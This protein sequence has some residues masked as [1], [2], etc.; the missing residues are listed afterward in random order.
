MDKNTLE[1]STEVEK[2]NDGNESNSGANSSDEN[3]III[4]EMTIITEEN[5]PQIPTNR[6]IELNEV[7]DL[8]SR[9]NQN[10]PESGKQTEFDT[11]SEACNQDNSREAS[12]AV[13]CEKSATNNSASTMISE[14]LSCEIPSE[15]TLSKSFSKVSNETTSDQLDYTNISNDTLIQSSSA[16]TLQT[17]LIHNPSQ[18]IE[19]KS[20]IITTQPFTSVIT[21][22]S[23]AFQEEEVKDTSSSVIEDTNS[24]VSE[25]NTKNFPIKANTTPVSTELAIN[26]NISEVQQ[27]LQHQSLPPM[28]ISESSKT[29]PT[30]SET[31]EFE[32]AQTCATIPESLDNLQTKTSIPSKNSAAINFEVIPGGIGAGTPE[33]PKFVDPNV[34]EKDNSRNELYAEVVVIN[35]DD[36]DDDDE[37][38]R[39]ENEIVSKEQQPNETVEVNS[40]TG[41]EVKKVEGTEV[42]SDTVLEERQNSVGETSYKVDKAKP[43]TMQFETPRKPAPSVDSRTITRPSKIRTQ[44]LPEATVTPFSKTESESATAD[45][46]TANTGQSL[47]PPAVSGAPSYVSSQPPQILGQQS[48]I[49]SRSQQGLPPNSVQQQVAASKPILQQATAPKIIPQSEHQQQPFA[50]TTPMRG[51]TH[52]VVIPPNITPSVPVISTNPTVVSNAPVAAQGPHNPENSQREERKSLQRVRQRTVTVQSQISLDITAAYNEVKQNACLMFTFGSFIFPRNM[53]RQ[54]EWMNS[55]D[56]ATELV[57]RVQAIVATREKEWSAKNE[58]LTQLLAHE[59]KRNEPLE[60]KAAERLLAMAEYEK[61][62]QE[63]VEELRKKNSD[64]KNCLGESKS[65]GRPGPERN[66]SPDDVTQLLKERDQ[67]AE[68]VNSL[69]TS[70]GELF[71]RYEKLRQ[72]SV[73]IKRNEDSVKSAS[74]EMARR[75]S[76]LVEKFEMLRRNAEEQLDLANNEIERLIKQHEADTLG[77]RLKVKHQESKIDS[78][79]VSLEARQKELESMTAIFEEVITKAEANDAACDA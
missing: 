37:R 76:L 59:Q 36:D 10:S 25:N 60:Q 13:I 42:A 4:P 70:Y 23:A 19:P 33:I 54:D 73:E 48:S 71:R 78:L 68:E 47:P 58:K 65:V 28:T 55:D 35:D 69:E 8:P 30:S 14:S 57:R 24:L 43:A 1:K 7:V 41:S 38:R 61:L 26:A 29:S 63:F 27:L 21:A 40:M 11:V 56:P 18:N 62:V 20:P 17:E 72:T 9:Q 45:M 39:A 32:L 79:T 15:Q 2:A 6:T 52:P 16:E 49:A 75:Y 34:M 46:L 77:L 12:N 44:Q 74:E 67:L 50:T 66:L 31:S 53:W 22:K 3:E 5:L 64:E 51:V